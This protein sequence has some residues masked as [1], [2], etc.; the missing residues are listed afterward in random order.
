[1]SFWDNI[2]DEEDEEHKAEEEAQE[3]F[4]SNKDCII[5]LIDAQKPM[6]E[7]NDKGEIPFHNAI[8]CAIATLTDKIISSDSDL[9]GICFYGT[10]TLQTNFPFTLF[11][12]NKRKT[13]TTS[14]GFTFLWIWIFLM[15]KKSST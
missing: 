14:K 4:L 3:A 9:M 15:R 13:P 11:C 7:R 5:F 10:V 6:F 8:K 12:R 1:M 2:F